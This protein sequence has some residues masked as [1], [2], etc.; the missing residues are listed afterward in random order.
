MN[1]ALLAVTLLLVVTACSSGTAGSGQRPA[2]VAQPAI[3]VELVTP[4]FFARQS[5]MPMTLEVAITNRATVP[6]I[7]REIEIASPGMVQWTLRPRRH[8]YNQTIAPGDTATLNFFTEAMTTMTEPAEPLNTR[9][10]V[11]L[12]AKGVFFREIVLTRGS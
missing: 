1:R 3:R 6:I 7:V 2:D 5:T 11:F 9:T 12:E 4:V 10:F 8:R